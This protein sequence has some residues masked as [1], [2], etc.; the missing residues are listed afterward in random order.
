MTMISLSKQTKV[1]VVGLGYVGIP[2]AS[3][4][5]K[6]YAVLGFDVD[7]SKVDS[8]NSGICPILDECVSTDFQKSPFRATTNMS[9]LSD[10]DVILVCVPTPVDDSEKPDMKYLISATK[11]I[12]ANLRKGQ[13]IVI[14]STIYPGTT[15]EVVIPILEQNGLV[16]GEDFGVGY[17]PERV[18]PGNPQFNVENIARVL[19]TFKGA[20]NDL[21]HSFYQE[22]IQAEVVVLSEIRA[23]EAVKILENTFRDVN[24]AFI[25]E[26]AKS[27]DNFGINIYEVIRGASTKPFG[28]MPFYPGPGVGGHCI[29]VD[30]YYLIEKAKNMGFKHSFL[31]MAREINNSMPHYVAELVQN[32]LNDL[33]LPVKDIKIG[34]LGLSYK[35]NV[36]D[37]RGSPSLEI[38]KILQSKGADV[39]HF[40]PFVLEKS[41]VSSARELLA[42]CDVIIFAC[43]HDQFKE[44]QVKDFVDCR[45]RFILDTKN[46]LP[47][48][49]LEDEGIYCKTLGSL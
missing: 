11:N 31:Q 33:R 25:N 16:C 2:L 30:P 14:E 5:A 45:V 44:I 8:L 21:L 40:D 28:F 46:F 22:M 37:L 13:L 47:R 24:I 43:A 38:G 29:P 23:A 3:L 1:G 27:F 7:Q 6:H 19:S 20:H 10:M 42:I 34:V 35:R 18:D 12:A 32:G 49:E 41:S 39:L 15:Q 4:A 26:M 17:C 9:Y 48:K 36:G